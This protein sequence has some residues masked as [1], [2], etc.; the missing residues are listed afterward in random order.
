MDRLEV[1]FKGK[2]IRT[3]K[4]TSKLT[5]DFTADAGE[6]GW[7]A[8]RAF[9]KPD[10]TVRYAHTS[11]VYIEIPGDAGI[12]REDARFFIDWIDREIAF[13]RQLPGFREPAHRD[14]MIAL[15]T[16]AREVYSKLAER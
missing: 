15:F 13:Y 16:S 3:V 7:F 14:A 6:S 8:A 5:A 12:V 9:E 11:P 4:G 10:H 2:T 1:V